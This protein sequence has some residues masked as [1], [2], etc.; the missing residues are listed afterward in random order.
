MLGKMKPNTPEYAGK[1]IITIKKDGNH[2]FS[3]DYKPLNL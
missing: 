2:R 1:I 3:Y